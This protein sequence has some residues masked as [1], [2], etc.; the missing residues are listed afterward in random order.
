MTHGQAII[1]AL[2]SIT[3]NQPRF[4]RQPKHLDLTFHGKFLTFSLNY[5]D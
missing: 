1:H 2:N 5:M 4:G 3:P